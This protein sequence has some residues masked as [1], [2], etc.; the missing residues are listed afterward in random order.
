MTD[1]SDRLPPWALDGRSAALAAF[2]RGDDGAAVAELAAETAPGAEAH[3]CADGE[4]HGTVVSSLRFEHE[5]VTVYLQ[6]Q[7]RG[8]LRAVSGLACGEYD[9]AVLN[10]RRPGSVR[11]LRVGED[12]TFS[13][14]DL[15]PGPISL[16]LSGVAPTTV[17]TGWFTI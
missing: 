9:H 10:V 17:V 13:L 11:S 7:A 16:S 15:P 4:A 6:V 8:R 12:G 2:D 1:R 5:G 14:S 3:R